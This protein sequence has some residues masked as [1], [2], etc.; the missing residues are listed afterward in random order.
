M[1]GDMDAMRGRLEPGGPVEVADGKLVEVR[2]VGRAS[3][4]LGTLD[5]G[6]REAQLEG[7]RCGDFAA[8][9]IS[10]SRLRQKG[11][12]LLENAAGLR[13][14]GGVVFPL[15]QTPQGPR[16]VTPRCGPGGR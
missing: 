13:H 11:F 2:G 10:W 7:V 6:V 15:E 9:L 3:I 5:G 8:N 14:P 1:F 16:F 12:T 4:C